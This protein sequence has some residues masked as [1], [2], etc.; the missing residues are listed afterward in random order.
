MVGRGEGVR[1]GGED[2]SGDD[3]E[4]HDAHSELPGNGQLSPLASGCTYMHCMYICTWMYVCMYEKC[5]LVREVLLDTCGYCS[6][7]DC[8][9]HAK[10]NFPRDVYCAS[11]CVQKVCHS[12]IKMA[13]LSVGVCSNN[14][15]FLVWT[16]Y[17]CGVALCM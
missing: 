16:H 9:V 10:K 5:L 7:T 8:T 3:L 14:S 12:L 1:E 4:F 15:A 13:H 17:V 6:I 2:E 11:V